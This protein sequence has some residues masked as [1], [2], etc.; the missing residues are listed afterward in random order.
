MTMIFQIASVSTPKGV[1][2]ALSEVFLF[3]VS[4][5][6]RYANALKSLS[7]SADRS[8]SRRGFL[9]RKKKLIWEVLLLSFGGA[10]LHANLRLSMVLSISSVVGRTASIIL[11]AL[12]D[13]APT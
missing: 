4:D 12:S 5:K 10:V 9:N 11:P 3:L 2:G 8:A 7:F 1:D 6:I 13:K